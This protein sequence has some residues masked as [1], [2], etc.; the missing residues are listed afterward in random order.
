MSAGE[1][2]S[3]FPSLIHFRPKRYSPGLTVFLSSK[4]VCR[5]MEL[6]YV[7]LAFTIP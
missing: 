1:V 7:A 5:T 2:K 6:V 3:G 4:T